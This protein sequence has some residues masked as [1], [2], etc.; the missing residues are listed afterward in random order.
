MP[1]MSDTQYI[2]LPHWPVFGRVLDQWNSIREHLHG[3]RRGLPV[4]SVP[5]SSFESID[6]PEMFLYV[7]RIAERP[8]VERPK[9]MK[10]GS[11]FYA[12]DIDELY[13]W[14]E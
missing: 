14:V 1:R 3:V 5:G 10:N 9:S 12:T 7:H 4:S 13:V 6:T 8:L 11:L 2:T